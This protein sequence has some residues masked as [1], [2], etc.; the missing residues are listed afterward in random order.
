MGGK[1]GKL[2]V[3]SYMG[4]LE[5]RTERLRPLEEQWAAPYINIGSAR[6]GPQEIWKLVLEAI[7][8]SL[9]AYQSGTILE[10]PDIEMTKSGPLG[11]NVSCGTLFA[12]YSV[13]SF[14][15]E[16][17]KEAWLD[18]WLHMCPQLEGIAKP[19]F[20]LWTTSTMSHWP[21]GKCAAQYDLVPRVMV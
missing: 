18:E 21:F 12:Q 2:Y 20:V 10:L 1:S 8:G 9:T 7:P 19:V 11:G 3:K 4:F 14:A 13:D 6:S 16:G 17:N 5:R 15:Y